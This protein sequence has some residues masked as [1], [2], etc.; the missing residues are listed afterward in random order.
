MGK[1]KKKVRGDTDHR[2]CRLYSRYRVYRFIVTQ[3]EVKRE[4]ERRVLRM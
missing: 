3:Y 2:S 4:R 1:E